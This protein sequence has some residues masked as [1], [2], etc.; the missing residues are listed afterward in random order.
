MTGRSAPFRR[1][2]AIMVAGTALSQGLVFLGLVV[3]AHLYGPDA[4]GIQALFMS[5]SGLLVTLASLRLDL[6]LVLEKSDSDARSVGTQAIV[7]AVVLGALVALVIG[8]FGGQIGQLL[9]RQS[10]SH[11]W[12][13][14]VPLSIVTGVAYQV[15]ISRANRSGRFMAI[16]GADAT[17]GVV[18]VA[19]GLV[20]F[21][22]FRGDADIALAR[23]L[24]QVAS[25]LALAYAGH[26]SIAWASR[27]LARGRGFVQT[28]RRH[29]QFLVFN[30]PYSLIGAFA[31]DL[32][33]LVFG[34]MSGV[35]VTAAYSLARALTVAPV[36]L[37]SSAVSRAFYKEAVDNIGSPQL[38]R[39]VVLLTRLGLLGALVPFAWLSA[40]GSELLPTLLG[41]EWK[42]AGQMAA[43]LAPAVWM[44]LQ[45]GWPERMF[46]VTRRQGVSF[47]IQMAFDS[48]HAVVV[49]TTLALTGSP[50]LTV[51]AFATSMF[52]FH[53]TYLVA[54]YK[55]AGYPSAQLVRDIGLSSGLYVLT[56]LAFA[57]LRSRSDS[58]LTMWLSL[59]AAGVAT[60]ATLA[61]VRPR[62]AHARPETV[63]VEE[64]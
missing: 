62:V 56:W 19:G 18:F 12:L 40:W 26:L 48:L 5:I 34:A 64:K 53:V 57:G 42:L 29:R 33:L 61:A 17:N 35:A 54:V 2:A 3:L 50:L 44:S 31:R 25:V 30:T 28:W 27:R 45:T 15:G 14:L 47:T 1:N 8:L 37:F 38:H 52:A 7:Q 55:V 49:L 24:A 23:Q 9:T 39:T 4:I 32:P 10:D 22:T 43:L 11:T 36:V 6:A 13:Y 21:V 60:V 41:D 20:L 46:E 59:V 16:A 51:A 58:Q 63:P